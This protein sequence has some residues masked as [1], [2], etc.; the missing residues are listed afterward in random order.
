MLSSNP[1][2]LP[3]LLRTPL[4]PRPSPENPTQPHTHS[5]TSTSVIR[6]INLFSYI[7]TSIPSLL[8]QATKIVY[9]FLRRGIRSVAER[10][11]VAEGAAMG[12]ISGRSWC[13]FGGLGIDF[14]IGGRV[15]GN[16]AQVDAA[17]STLLAETL[18]EGMG[19]EAY[20][21]GHVPETFSN[22]G[23]T[24]SGWNLWS[25]GRTRKSWPISK[26]SVQMEQPRFSSCDALSLP[27]AAVAMADCAGAMPS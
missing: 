17:V 25:Q 9:P 5:L 16:W 7:A 3:Q 1:T 20:H 19:S 8:S 18:R 12:L 23:S 24:H 13:T 15:G 14:G 21:K 4:P 27:V 22:H 10:E 26:S 11:N 2:A 6:I